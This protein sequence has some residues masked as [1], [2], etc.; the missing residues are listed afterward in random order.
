MGGTTNLWK[1]NKT[2]TSVVDASGQ[3]IVFPASKASYNDNKLE[4]GTFDSLLHV[5]V[6]KSKKALQEEGPFVFRFK[7]LPDSKT[8]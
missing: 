8:Y 2:E 5:G 1:H 3:K 6:G 4:F 7:D